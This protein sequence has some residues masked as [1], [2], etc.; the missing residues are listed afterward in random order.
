M[1]GV[2]FQQLPNV[3]LI[4]TKTTEKIQQPSK[5]VKADAFPKRHGCKFSTIKRTMANRLRLIKS[6][7][8]HQQ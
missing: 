8:N 1:Q 4:H 2:I 7:I 3:I 6:F 5:P